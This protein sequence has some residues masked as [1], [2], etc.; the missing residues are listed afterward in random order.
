MVDPKQ[1]KLALQKGGRPGNVPK[2]E[3]AHVTD[4][5]HGGKITCHTCGAFIKEGED[6]FEY[7]PDH[8][9]VYFHVDHY[10]R[11]DHYYGLDKPID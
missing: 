2:F 5:A 3:P 1:V 4:P 11:Y 10:N 9:G 8:P 7:V 6:W